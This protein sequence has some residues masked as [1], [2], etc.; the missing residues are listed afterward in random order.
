VSDPLVTTAWLAGRL[1]DPKVVVMDGSWHMPASGRDARAEFAAGHIPSAVFFGIDEICDHSTNLPH[2]LA[3]P[4]EFAVAVR[5]LGVSSDSHVVVYDSFGLFSAARV[6]WN[7]RSMGHE[8]ASVLDGGLPRWTAEGHPLE[9]GWRTRAHGDFKARPVA[10]L[11]ADLAAM[12]H[13]VDVGLPQIVDARG[14]DRFRGETP[15]PREGLRGGHIPAA[16]N[17]PWSILVRDGVLLEP[18]ALAKAFAAAGVDLAGPIIT[19][20]GSGV[21]AALLALALARI[22]REDAA[23]YDGSWSEWGALSDTPIATGPA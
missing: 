6:W 16:R 18:A 15:E 4:A 1:D 2:M 22:G 11:V 7:F 21:S 13:A 17:T 20:C 12:R 9:T 5:R 19:T 8:A 10:A 3:E 14:A 23:V